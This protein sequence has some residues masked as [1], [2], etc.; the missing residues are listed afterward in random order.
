GL[1]LCYHLDY[2][3][4]GP[5]SPQSLF[6]NVSPESFRTELAPSRTFLLEAEAHALRQA[7]IGSR[8]TAADLLI[9]G[10][11]G[12]IGNTLRYP[13]ECVRHKI[14]DLLGDLALLARDLSG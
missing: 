3:R 10:P 12:V 9:F 4:Q 13:D 7:G 8:T 1:V 11:D 6:L 14:L 5:I 2:G